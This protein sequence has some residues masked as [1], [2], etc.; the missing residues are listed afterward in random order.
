[1]YIHMHSYLQV[2]DYTYEGLNDKFMAKGTKIYPF[3][4]EVSILALQ[5][6]ISSI[7]DTIFPVNITDLTLVR[8]EIQ[9][10]YI[11]LAALFSS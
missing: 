5:E 8:A 10:I 11:V 1:M 7:S 6:I 2:S 3:F 9:D 4:V